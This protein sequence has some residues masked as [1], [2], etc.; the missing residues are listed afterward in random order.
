MDCHIIGVLDQKT[1]FLLIVYI[2]YTII[3]Q[4]QEESLKTFNKRHLKLLFF[5]NFE[6]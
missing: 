6:Y 3:K 2:G 5:L 1:I 4:T